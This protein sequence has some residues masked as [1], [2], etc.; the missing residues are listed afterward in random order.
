MSKPR[1]LAGAAATLLAAGCLADPAPA[2]R[3]AGPPPG[4]PRI[5]VLGADGRALTPGAVIEPGTSLT[6]RTT[7]GTL[8][9]VLVADHTTGG[10]ASRVPRASTTPVTR[11]VPGHR[12]TITA[13]ALAPAGDAVTGALPLSVA[14][15]RRVLKFAITPRQGATVAPG[16]P[17][18]V[19]FSHPV[20]ERAAVE[21]GMSVISSWPLP[22]GRWHW[23]SPT[24]AVYRYDP[25]GEP[26]NKIAVTVDLA[27]IRAG[28]GLFGVSAER[29]QF[30]SAA[31]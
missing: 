23:P 26:R 20:R 10:A 6:V 5:Q 30:T 4:P 3:R 28:D 9:R 22:G 16:T 31:R 12:Y 8:L 13:T 11:L 17:I 21:A 25:A 18:Q 19:R 2:A 14:A 27:G 1:L 15:A 7:R 24:R 29:V